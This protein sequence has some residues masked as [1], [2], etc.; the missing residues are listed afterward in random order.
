MLVNKKCKSFWKSGD[1]ITI[2]IDTS[3]IYNNPYSYLN[4][5]PQYSLTEESSLTLAVL[6]TFLNP[7]S[8]LC[9]WLA[10]IAP[11]NS[12]GLYNSSST[13]EEEKK[14]RLGVFMKKV[15]AAMEADEPPG[16][17]ARPDTAEEN[18]ETVDPRSAVQEDSVVCVD[19]GTSSTV[20]AVREND[21]NVH[22]LRIGG[23]DIEMGGD[24]CAEWWYES[25]T[26]LEF[27]SVND[28]LSLWR[29]DPWR[30]MA[31]GRHIKCGRL[32]RNEL[33]QGQR[34]Q[35]GISA[36]KTF[37][38][39]LPGTTPVCLKDEQGVDFELSPLPVAEAADGIGDFDTRPLDPIELYAYFIGLALNNQSAFGGR[40]Y[41]DYAMTFPVKFPREVRQRILQGFYRGLLRS[42]PPSLASSPDWQQS[43]PFT[44][45]EHASE[46]TAFAAGVL[47]YLGIEPTEDGV[48]FAV[49]DFGGGTTDFAFG[50]WRL[51]T[52]E[53][54]GNNGWEQVLDILDVAGDE[55]LG[56]EH[57]LALLVYELLRG[58]AEN[59]R[60]CIAAG[61]SVMLPPGRTPFDG[62]ELL[63]ADS[64]AARANT[65]TLCELLR[66]L[67]EDGVLSD[68]D[69]G[70][71]EVS[72]LDHEGKEARLGLAADAESLVP[73][74]KARIRQ[75]VEAFFTTFRQAFKIHG[76]RPQQLHVLLAG[77]ACRSPLVREV[78]ADVL[79]G[80]VPTERE[81]VIIHNELLPDIGA[82]NGE[83]PRTDARPHASDGLPAPTLKT[84]VALGLLRLLPGETTG[85]VERNRKAE[86][87]FLFTVGIFDH[88]FLKPVVQRNAEYGKWHQGGKVF[89]GGISLLGYTASPV[90]MEGACPRAECRQLR[91]AWGEANFGKGVFIKATGPREIVVALGQL[92]AEVPDESTA[93]VCT[94]KS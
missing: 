72:L 25:P 90:A 39:G 5:A 57:L 88:N 8:D 77:N 58:N 89:R 40:I 16:L 82:E 32:A 63:F 37:A 34:A 47:P 55:N 24:N 28:L 71:L 33:R 87:P 38:R 18:W 49:F 65:V 46:P 56:G 68:D 6:C 23:L 69:T 26:A 75:G 1:K 13:L 83:A 61:V 3:T 92:D 85:M 93:Q 67:W 64:R 12:L 84:G 20:A 86:A 45:T 9:L 62:S 51:P 60:K 54:Q 79:A 29:G 53:E 42:M 94:L 36:I 43:C 48:P 78:F 7:D 10:H 15:E 2:T 52:P 50:L 80:I 74:L 22:L 19:F 66:P 59:C 4:G 73:T 17:P 14:V 70:L 76:I 81:S 31:T 44:L 30:P 11:H 27:T 35:S 91:F 21:G 41:C